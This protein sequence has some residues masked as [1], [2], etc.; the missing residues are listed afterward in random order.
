[1]PAT[2]RCGPHPLLLR[3]PAV[4]WLASGS[5][6]TEQQSCMQTMFCMTLRHIL[7]VKQEQKP[8]R[9]SSCFRAASAAFWVAGCSAPFRHS[10]KPGMSAGPN[11]GCC[12][13]AGGGGGMALQLALRYQRALRSF[14]VR[15]TCQCARSVADF[16]ALVS[17]LVRQSGSSAAAASNTKLLQKRRIAVTLRAHE[18]SYENPSRKSR[19]PIAA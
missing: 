15:Q 6:H 12:G 9:S 7:T 16:A 5:D 1:M 14:I 17:P 8:G 18:E 13:R 11:G 19:S 3:S 4:A 2:V 10:N